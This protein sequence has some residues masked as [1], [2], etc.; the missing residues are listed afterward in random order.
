MR[1]EGLVAFCLLAM[2]PACATAAEVRVGAGPSGHDL[3]WRIDEEGQEQGA[4]V[5][6]D[7][8]FDRAEALPWL[9]KPRPYVGGAVSLDGFTNFAHAGV[10]WRKNWRRLYIEAGTGLAVHDGHINLADP[11]PALPPAEN[12]RRAKR[13]AELIQYGSRVLLHFNAALGYRVTD[14]F[15][16][17]IGTQHWSHGGIFGKDNEG[18]D[19]LALRGSWRFG[20]EASR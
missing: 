6:A 9:G 13:Q 7:V 20:T 5:T 8:V 4:S 17:E 2:A 11:D 18:A 19:I 10:L 14:R 1:R 15:A 12:A 3:V 16:M